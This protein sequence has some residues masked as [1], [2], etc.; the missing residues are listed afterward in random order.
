MISAETFRTSNL[1]DDAHT[2]QKQM[3]STKAY[4]DIIPRTPYGK[5]AT[6]FESKQ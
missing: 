2:A 1:K 4:S 3:S 5:E 6:R